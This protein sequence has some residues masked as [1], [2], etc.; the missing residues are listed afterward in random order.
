MGM[1][2]VVF[3]PLAFAM[4]IAFPYGG[5]LLLRRLATKEEREKLKDWG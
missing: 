4:G 3:L 1:F 5:Y 2:D